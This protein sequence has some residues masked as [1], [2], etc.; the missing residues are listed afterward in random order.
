[1]PEDEIWEELKANEGFREKL[2]E[3]RV[4]SDKLKIIKDIA[5]IAWKVFIIILIIL[6]LLYS[7]GFFNNFKF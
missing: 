2:M 3:L 5:N 6:Y 1:M 7:G 4:L